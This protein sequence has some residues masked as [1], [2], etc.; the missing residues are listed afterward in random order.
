MK[1]RCRIDRRLALAVLPLALWACQ[2]DADPSAPL[3]PVGEARM[4]MLQAQCLTNGGQWTSTGLGSL[5]VMRT[6]DSG[7]SCQA[8]TQCDGACL[9]RSGTCSPVK[10]LLG[11]N[12]VLTSS[13]LRVNECVE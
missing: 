8:S 5:C 7:K 4:E 6:G 11:C 1:I 13:G 12:D 10:P 3:P 2:P 9:A